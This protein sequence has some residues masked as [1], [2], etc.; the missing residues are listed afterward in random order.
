MAV[1]FDTDSW[2][3]CPDEEDLFLP[4]KVKATF[5]R[6]EVGNVTFS[7]G[8]EHTIS[9]KDSESLMVCDE[10]SLAP[11]ENMVQLND[12]NNPSILHNLRIRFQQDTIYTSVGQI[13]VSVNPFK[14]LPI[15]TP[16][17]LDKYKSGSRGQPP[18]CYGVADDAYRQMINNGDNHAIIISGESGAGKTEAMKLV[19]Q[20]VAEVSGKKET[21]GPSLEEKIL[22][23]NP[24]MEAFGNAKTT[25]NNNSSRFGK[26]T[27]INFDKGGAIIGGRI[28]NYLL[29]KS[30]VVTQ[31]ENERNYHIFYQLLA[32]A[33]KT[34][35]ESDPTKNLKTKYGLGEAQDYL[36]TNPG[37]RL[38]ANKG[39]GTTVHGI[40]DEREFDDL[41]SAMKVIDMTPAEVDNVL[42]IVTAILNLG[43]VSYVPDP[44]AQG[45]DKVKVGDE[46]PL[47][48]FCE[49]LAVDKAIMLR[50]LISRGIG[51][52]SVIQVSYT[53]EEATQ[54]RDALAKTIYGNLFDWLVR[55]INTTLTV[56]GSFANIIGVLD[57]FG[58]E[59]FEKNSFEQL[60]INYCNEK[61][62]FHFNEHIFKL[63]QEQYKSEGVSVDNITFEDNQP[64]LDLI[65]K[66]R[67]GIIA[68][69]D[70][71][72]RTPKGND[73]K[74]LRKLDKEYATKGKEHKNYQKPKPRAKDSEKS[75]IFKHYAGPVCYDV[76]NFMEKSKDTLHADVASAM[77]ISKDPIIQGLFPIK[78]PEASSGGGRRGRGGGKKSSKKTLG[79]QF[80][81]QL[82]SLMKILNSTCPHFIRCFK[83]NKEKRG[84]I[85][86]SDMMMQQLNYAGLLEVCRIR[87]IGYPI[88]HEFDAFF[89]RYT[90]LDPSAGD[91]DALLGKLTG[92]V[93]DAKD[94]AKG[95]T[96]VFLR[97][98]QAQELETARETA[99]S[100]V[101]TKMQAFARR[102]M[103]RI[104]H[105]RY[106]AIIQ[107]LTKAVGDRD[108]DQIEHW[109]RQAG[110]L[111]FRGS[112]L[113]IV[114]DAA[115]LLE[116]IKEERRVEQLLKD[117]I[118][119]RE[120]NGLLGAISTAEEM[121]MT[122]EALTSAKNLVGRIQE[123]TKV[124]AE[125][126]D[127]LKQRDRAALEACKKKA[128]DLELNDTAEFKQAA[129]LLERIRLE[130][131]AVGQLEQAMSNENVNELQA[132]LQQMVEMG[133][134]DATRF[135]HF[136]DTIQGAKKTLETLKARN[137]EKQSL[138]NAM[139]KSDIGNLEKILASATACGVDAE[140]LAS[141]KTALERMRK[142][143]A[144]MKVVA[145]A[146]ASESIDKL[147]DALDQASALNLYNDDI[148][149][150][151]S[152]K[153]QL[154]AKESA[155]TALSDAL[156]AENADDISSSLAAALKLGVTG[157]EIT[158]AETFLSKLGAKAQILGKLA[159]AGNSLSELDGVIDELKAMDGM[160]ATVEKAME[161]RAKLL[162]QQTAEESIQSAI[163]K[164][165]YDALVVALKN[166]DSSG[167]STNPLKAEVMKMADES[168]QKLR[169]IQ[170]A[171]TDLKAAI[172]SREKKNIVSQLEVA[173]G[174]GVEGYPECDRARALLESLEKEAKLTNDI[175]EALKTKD[176]DALTKLWNTADKIGLNNTAVQNAGMLVNREKTMKATLDKIKTAT[177]TWDLDLMNECME[178]CIQLG[179][180][181]DE[182]T[183]AKKTLEEMNKEAQ[184]ASKIQAAANTLKM[185][186][187][188]KNGIVAADIKPLT[189]AMEASIAA[190][191]SAESKSYLKF[192]G[193]KENAE[194]QLAMYEELKAVIAAVD[195]KSAGTIYET[196][197]L[198]SKA[199]DKA[200]D[201]N[202][203]GVASVETVKALYREYDK[204]VQ[205]ARR[206]RNEAS[207]ED[208]EEE[209]DSDEEEEDEEEVER[210]RQEGYKRALQPRFHFTK[211]SRIRNPEDYVR[212]MWFGKKK[213]MDNQLQWQNTQI[214]KS[215]TDVDG[216]ATKHSLKI[217]KCILG[218]C[219]E[220]S[221]NYPDMLAQDILNTGV[222]YPDVCD[223][224][225]VQICKHLTNNENEDSR[226]RCW[227]L[228][229]MC[230]GTF[231][232]S[233][234]FKDH[235]YNFILSN[236]SDEGSTT[237]YVQYALRRLEGIIH[238]GASGYVPEVAEIAAYKERPPIVVT[239]ELVDGGTLTSA[240]PITPDLNVGKVTEICNHFLDLEDDRKKYFGI[241]LVEDDSKSTPLA[242]KVFMGD[243]VVRLRRAKAENFKFV[244]KRKIFL[245]RIDHVSENDVYNR[246][247]FLQTVDEIIIG[248]IT[249]PTV[250]SAAETAAAAVYVDNSEDFEDDEIPSNDELLEDLAI[251]E[252]VA[253]S[254]KNSLEE[255]EW[256]DKIGARIKTLIGQDTEELQN[257]IVENA[258]DDPLYGVR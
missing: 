222:A 118:A 219:G 29:E 108:G 111:P 10:Q 184:H 181:G 1:K 4:G 255:N 229:C 174:L 232:P 157:S 182:V 196:F 45:E 139:E 224:I 223:E 92:G 127:A 110:E 94:F 66:K 185:K 171:L 107:S 102:F 101:A 28:I 55:K 244:Y 123:E 36:Y 248:N 116:V 256:A 149:K 112:H 239:I 26:W 105:K 245:K 3:W 37:N 186:S 242:S 114:R 20:Y 207:D 170:S 133:L 254:W 125:L 18:H 208:S 138:L 150:A 215:I 236:K 88:R 13:L 34:S 250:E 50:S 190:G 148:G 129:A 200:L 47:D 221:M 17:W 52:H 130:E 135:P 48:K 253:E 21:D 161:T 61:L 238:N 179:I 131:E 104:K 183:A 234:E 68:M 43:N 191:L 74:M 128:E 177:E 227:Q 220:K 33:E 53:L 142:E 233:G 193:I 99:L 14:L 12:L 70:E 31:S 122:S 51:A 100:K 120:I 64:A 249:T 115:A 46:G 23:A 27:E 146:I 2:V 217:H 60:C 167:L 156:K 136:V 82:N 81:E 24:V 237:E 235:L 176:M 225:Y 35:N 143:E 241:F 209:S 22:K 25:R 189:D 164:E 90:C 159:S 79:T 89:K 172:D 258:K 16:E 213:A 206:A 216:K 109:V 152:L 169:V 160:E 67:I 93:L 197:K 7:N 210:K 56:E 246:L 80:K 154:E 32:G 163:K 54:T 75:F 63:E 62:Q 151:K 194:A 178:S 162:E 202:M 145:S 230:V 231:P 195:N 106:L 49:L 84:D 103:Q 9:A 98:A 187:Q 153:S 86:T 19:L 96:K 121:K 147:E 247:Q 97:N 140:T 124:I 40:N 72:I 201:L 6:G 77:Q 57:I 198:I 41:L 126:A 166:A 117:A 59:S 211:F 192:L 218:Y 188:S 252:Y 85:F 212:G 71:E 180:E 73:V 91:L 113:K 69:V 173:K 15:Y 251:M 95:N 158:D 39:E 83:P 58:F 119:K 205:A 42:R 87:Q 155:K 240:L 257:L 165:D 132:Y 137:N 199:H 144:V 8:E 76:T 226:D 228:L 78:A 11:I 38:Q 203:D 168:L 175:E 65:E 243:E 30:R 5:K 134:D 141:A 214:K 204:L 44:A